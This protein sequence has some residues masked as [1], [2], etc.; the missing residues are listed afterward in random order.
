MKW[1]C[2]SYSSIGTSFD[3]ANVMIIN[4]C[5]LVRACSRWYCICSDRLWISIQVN[6]HC[7]L[8]NAQNSFIYRPY[9]RKST[10]LELAPPSVTKFIS[11][12]GTKSDSHK[13]LGTRRQITC[14]VQLIDSPIFN[15][16]RPAR[17]PKK[18]QFAFLFLVSGRPAVGSPVSRPAIFSNELSWF[19]SVTSSEYRGNFLK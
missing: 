15:L 9:A 18:T 3:A 5:V 4:L 8:W 7:L 2:R 12:F 13:T 10:P 16:P 19:F 6:P 14:T 11:T 17:T 1:G